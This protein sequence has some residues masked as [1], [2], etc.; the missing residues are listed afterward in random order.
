VAMD[1]KWDQ[2]ERRRYIRIE[3][4]FII[5]YRDNDDPSVMIEVSQLKNISMGGM[6]CVTARR[7]AP[8]TRMNIELKTPYVSKPVPLT[9]TVLDST[10]KVPGII[11]ETRLVFDRLDNQAE[12]VLNKIVGLF[13]RMVKEKND[14]EQA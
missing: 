6:C 12:F 2:Q 13:S 5:T 8:S 7:Y 9:G 3:K 4:H 11:Y 14:N 10:E 1:D